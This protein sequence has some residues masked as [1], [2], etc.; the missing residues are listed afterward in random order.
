[1]SNRPSKFKRGKPVPPPPPPRA[2][3]LPANAFI[4]VTRCAST[5]RGVEYEDEDVSVSTGMALI[6]AGR[7]IHHARSRSHINMLAMAAMACG[8]SVEDLLSE[9]GNSL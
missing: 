8:M 9:Y 2:V 3:V 5:D 6:E 4:P 1:V 7:G